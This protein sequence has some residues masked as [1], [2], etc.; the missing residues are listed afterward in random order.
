MNG[1]R[2]RLG[3]PGSIA[4]AALWPPPDCTGPD[5]P[6]ASCLT[7]GQGFGGGKPGTGVDTGLET[8]KGFPLYAEALYPDQPGQEPNHTAYKCLFSKDVN[9]AAPTKGQFSDACKGGGYAVVGTSNQGLCVS[10]VEHTLAGGATVTAPAGGGTEGLRSDGDGGLIAN[11][12]FWSARK[13][14]LLRSS[15]AADS[16]RRGRRF[17][18]AMGSPSAPR[19]FRSIRPPRPNSARSANRC[20]CWSN[21]RASR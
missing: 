14:A 18:R 9:G 13:N 5:S 6:N 3:G 17:W 4:A 12:S 21:L 10:F 15:S 19:G 1:R 8:A 2:R 11:I 20:R 16:W 7:S